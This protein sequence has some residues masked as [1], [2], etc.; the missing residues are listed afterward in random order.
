V[1]TRSVVV[2]RLHAQMKAKML[3]V[4]VER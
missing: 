2:P 4:E 3:G 1:L